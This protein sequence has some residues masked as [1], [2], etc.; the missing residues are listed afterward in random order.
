[1]FP[2]T[3]TIQ[4][5]LQSAGVINN[6]IIHS[7]DVTAAID[8][9]VRFVQDYSYPLVN[10]CRT[11]KHH[12]A[13]RYINYF[14]GPLSIAN[15]VT[16]ITSVY[17]TTSMDQLSNTFNESKWVIS[18]CWT[19]TD[20]VYPI[21]WLPEAVGKRKRWCFCSWIGSKRGHNFMHKTSGFLKIWTSWHNFEMF[22]SCL[23]YYPDLPMFKMCHMPWSK[24]WSNMAYY[25][26]KMVIIS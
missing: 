12:L 16:Y 4:N 15:N 26:Q 7:D 11:E 6:V 22:D 10:I 20:A 25:G 17:S 13:V 14:H 9:Q 3:K 23:Q 5:I 19:L 24:H 18:W 1:M 21:S 2:Y 8:Q